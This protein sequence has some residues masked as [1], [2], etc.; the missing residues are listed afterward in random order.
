[1]L[2]LAAGL[3]SCEF[4]QE[5]F[6]DEPAALRIESTN[7]DIKAK[8]VAGSNNGWLIQYFVAGTDEMTFEGFNLF[9]KFY[10]T[11]KVTLSGNHRFLRNGNAGKY[12]EYTSYYEML[13]EEGSVLAFNTWNDILTVFVDPVS[14][15]FAP[16][17]IVND[18]EGM[19]G[20]DRL[21]MQSYSDDYMV[22]RGERHGAKAYFIK[23][24]RSPEQYVLDI[25]ELKSRV[26]NS[27]VTEYMLAA[28]DTTVY[29]SGL[30]RGYFEVVDRLDDPLQSST[31]ACVF[32]PDGFR[33]EHPFAL[34]SDTV[35]TFTVDAATTKLTS[36]N[37]T[38]TPC[39]ERYVGSR[40]SAN[41]AVT[42]TAD[43]GSA[44]FANLVNELS[45]N[46]TSNFS[47]QSFAGISFG[48]SNEGS[49]KS[50]SGLTF[51]F[52]TNKTSYI[53]AFQGT[54]TVDAK[55]GTLTINVDPADHST[56]Y[57]SYDKKG[58]GQYFDAI[59]TRMNGTYS[60]TVDAPFAPSVATFKKNGDDNWS[61]QAKLR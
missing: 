14:P 40:C 58:L 35:Q 54:V 19:H 52:K 4:E 6:F 12:T 43:G 1:M 49:G 48:R 10:E 42:I 37:A 46:V 26:A 7:A 34:K 31:Q 20:D 39:W 28:T 50:R 44:D 59:V 16:N 32:T 15:S 30:N 3:T 9:G 45:S 18:G 41:N 29:L 17:N 5:D 33:M 55:A 60:F 25:N 56:N 47:S 2:A 22:F 61:F 8:L 24:D 23:L 27:V 13:K 36:G 11:G 38:L 57:N 53:V 51:T 21:V